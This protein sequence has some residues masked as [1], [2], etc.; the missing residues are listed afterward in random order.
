MG[1]NKKKAG[2]EVGVVC[3]SRQI[4]DLNPSASNQ[5]SQYNDLATIASAKVENDNFFSCVRSQL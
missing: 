5:E 3:T 2:E 1:P 4:R